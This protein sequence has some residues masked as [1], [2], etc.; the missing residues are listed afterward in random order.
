MEKR[1]TIFLFETANSKV[2]MINIFLKC[3]M[4]KRKAGI[5]FEMP[6]F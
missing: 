2:E 6:D 5:F 4:V 1:D 3:Q